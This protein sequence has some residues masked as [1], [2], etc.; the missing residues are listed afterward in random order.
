M[1]R[2]S[3]LL[4]ATLLFVGGSCSTGYD[5]E[6]YTLPE[7][8]APNLTIE[9][10]HERYPAPYNGVYEIIDEELT[11][12]GTITSDDRAGNIYQSLYIEQ[13]GYALRIRVG[14]SQTAHRYP[15]G[16][17]LTVRLKGLGIGRERGVL[18]VGAP[19]SDYDNSE[20]KPIEAQPLIDEHLY[21][22]ER[23]ELLS[24][25]Q[26]TI[27]ELSVADCGRV[28][29]IGGL[30]HAPQSDEEATLAGYHR[31]EDRVGAAVHL[32]T[33]PYARFAQEAIPVGELTLRGIVEWI[34][35]GEHEGYVLIPR[36][37]EDIIAE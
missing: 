32:Y 15:K 14:L 8:P 26:R 18:Q 25:P 10:L 6:P 17:R 28:V 29:E 12:R 13:E 31:M 34:S 2:L 7:P 20:I 37:E 30:H 5:P 16:C 33:S 23:E 24:P 21:R 27:G 9:A 36:D 11:V 19:I 22:G 35:Q 1:R 3:L 4:T